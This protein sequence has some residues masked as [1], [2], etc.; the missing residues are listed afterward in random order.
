MAIHIG[1]MDDLKKAL[2]PEMTKMV[3]KLADRVYQT[4]NYFLQEYYGR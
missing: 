4:L 1:N 2:M 3:D